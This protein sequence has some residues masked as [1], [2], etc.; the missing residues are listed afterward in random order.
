VIVV[1]AA[2]GYIAVPKDVSS[3]SSQPV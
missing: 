1:V 2:A 3:R